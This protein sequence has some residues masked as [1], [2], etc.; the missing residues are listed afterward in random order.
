MPLS[1]ALVD[2]ARRVYVRE[3][4]TGDWVD[5]QPPTEQ[6]YGPWFPM[7]FRPQA[8]NEV[9][10]GN[11]GGYSYVDGVARV[12]MGLTFEDGSPVV[13]PDG[14]FLAFDADDMLEI[15]SAELGSARWYVNGGAVAIRRRRSLVGFR[16]ELRRAREAQVQEE[17]MDP[18]TRALADNPVRI[19]APVASDQPTPEDVG[20]TP[21]EIAVPDPDP[22]GYEAG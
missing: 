9:Q 15:E 18:S 1:R 17:P 7:R 20:V 5:G 12:L 19:G 11:R 13:A 3:D 4:P 16:A 14:T 10:V 2:R 8:Q 21:R 22:F 6:A